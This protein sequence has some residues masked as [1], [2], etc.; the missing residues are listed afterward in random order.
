MKK[1]ISLSAFNDLRK[2]CRNGVFFV[3]AIIS[4]MAAMTFVGM[5]VDLGMI[6]V[7]Q[8]RMQSSADA[9]ALA[10]AQEIV[11]GIREAGEQGET[12]VQA[13]QSIA[14]A[15]ARAMAENVCQMNGFFI[16]PSTDVELGHRLLAEDGVSYVE[17][18]GAPPYNMVKVVIRK[19]N[20]DSTKPDAKLLLIFAAVMGE[21]AHSITTK[22][23]AFIESRDIVA[24]LDYSGSMAFDSQLRSDTV[25]RIG[26]FAV[27]NGLDAIWNALAD[28]DVRFSDNESIS[29]FPAS[30]FCSLDSYE[31]TYIS[32]SPSDTVLEQLGIYTPGENYWDSWDYSSSGGG[33]YETSNKIGGYY[34]RKD[35]G[36]SLKRRS[37]SKGSWSDVSETSFPGYFPSAEATCIPFPQERK[38]A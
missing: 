11:V 21:R 38:N 3:L 34:W 20:A 4:L 29:K 36:G 31:G 25:N 32:S 33:R 5:S 26:L 35:V 8:T 37:K 27:E 7:I 10:A 14:V 28:S 9:A 19:T 16:E 13:V 15:V 17:T 22:A 30:G 1:S 23:V 12:N 24:V 6:T 2:H 18:W